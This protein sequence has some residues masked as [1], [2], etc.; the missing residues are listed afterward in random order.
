MAVRT[1]HTTNMYNCYRMRR[2]MTI[3]AKFPRKINDKYINQKFR[4]MTLITTKTIYLIPS[5]LIL[6]H[7]SKLSKHMPLIIAPLQKGAVLII[8]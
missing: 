3:T 4:K 1:S 6:I 7:L 2:L 8:K 5:H